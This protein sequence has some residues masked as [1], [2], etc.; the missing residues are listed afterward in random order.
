MSSPSS[1][2]PAKNLPD[3]RSALSPA[4]LQMPRMS[5]VDRQPEDELDLATTVP[6][7]MSICMVPYCLDNPYQRELAAHLREMGSTVTARDHINGLTRDLRA[8][9]IRLDVVHLH[10]LRTFTFRPVVVL[11]FLA[12]ILRLAMLRRSGCGIVWT[13]HNLY[14]H[15]ARHPWMERAIASLVARCASRL[16]VHSPSAAALVAKE[17]G[18]TDGGKIA[19]IPHGNYVGCYP[20]EIT[21]EQARDRLGLD[22]HSVVL[23]FLGKIRR[24]KGVPEL[25]STFQEL[26]AANAELLIA[27]SPLNPEVENDVRSAVT[28]PHVHLH[29]HFIPDEDIQVYMKAADAVVLPYQ[30]VLTSGAVVL[31]MS[32][33]KAC[34][35]AKIGCIPDMLDDNGAILYQ[36]DRP[37]GLRNAL[38]EALA[39]PARL[40]E[41]GQHNANRALEWGWDRIA[42]ETAEVYRQSTEE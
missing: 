3:F 14:G 12:F 35:A 18:I 38:T 21:R 19:I 30:D 8:G 24:Y 37:A 41:M 1:A 36:P 2:D 39:V 40:A 11:R 6:P 26:D 10:W 16:I 31:A 9:R 27:G 29:P 13:V 25:I 17:F 7:A 28:S 33:G 42:R 23:L 4:D 15:E 20:N 34:I 32:F 22:H 5:L